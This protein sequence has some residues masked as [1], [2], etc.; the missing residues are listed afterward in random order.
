MQCYETA[1]QVLSD[2]GS[3]YTD[4]DALFAEPVELPATA[5]FHPGTITTLDD[6]RAHVS[7]LF[8]VSRNGRARDVEILEQ[9]PPEDMGVRVSMH[10]M[11]REMRYRP[12]V[13]EGKVVAANAVNREYRFEY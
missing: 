11:L 10:D 9:N 13:R 5:V 2:D 6:E 7:I 12:I 8:N 3:I 4:P 1:W